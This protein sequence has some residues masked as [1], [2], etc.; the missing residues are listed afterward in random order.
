MAD[1][2]G[3]VADDDNLTDAFDPARA[4][5]VCRVVDDAGDGWRHLLASLFVCAALRPL[6]IRSTFIVA[7]VSRLQIRCGFDG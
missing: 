4:S 3:V 2:P 1:A 5:V 7:P 6:V